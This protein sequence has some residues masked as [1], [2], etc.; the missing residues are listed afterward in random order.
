VNYS[1][2]DPFTF[3]QTVP[4]TTVTGAFKTFGTPSLPG[5]VVMGNL[6]AN[7]VIYSVNP[8]RPAHPLRPRVRQRAPVLAGPG[9]R[10]ARQ[11]P[12]VQFP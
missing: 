6:M 3:E 12:G 8:G 1:S 5:E 2:P 4:C 10:Q 11:P 9:L 7:G